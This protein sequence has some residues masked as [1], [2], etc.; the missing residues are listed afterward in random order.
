MSAAAETPAPTAQPNSAAADQPSRSGLLLNLVRKLIDYGRELTATIRQRT[1]T[2]PFFAT[3]RFG[4]TDLA[5]ILARIARGLLLANALEARV[6]QRAAHLDAGPRPGRARSAAKAPAAP[7]AAEVDPGLARL[8][9][10]EQIAAEVRRRPIGAVIADIC[11]D[12]G[13]VP[14]HP[15]WRDVQLAIIRHG[16]SLAGLVSDILD[17]ACPLAARAAS[18]V[19][20]PALRQPTLRFEAP[21][22]TGPP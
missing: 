6:L 2:E 20:R 21:G 22:G 12:L 3:I 11:R 18:R 8:P 1:V 5:L 14:S 4:T 15:L 7:R 17:Q 19:A 9:T 13:I 10:A 16:G